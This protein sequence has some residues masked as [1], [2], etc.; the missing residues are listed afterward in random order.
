MKKQLLHIEIEMNFSLI[1]ISCHL[2]DYRFVWGANKALQANFSKT[3]AYCLQDKD[4]SFTQYE[5]ELELSTVYL[6]SN[7]SPKGYLV[8]A[9]PQ[10]DY[11]LMLDEP[12]G[13]EKLKP[14]IEQLRNM[15]QVLV[16]YEE[17][18]LKVKENFIF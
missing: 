10:V 7:R 1:G 3:T 2:K 14:W 17:Q 16:A 4:C 13:E 12:Y 5:Y 8:S 15:P 6:F 18:E 11:W 9:K